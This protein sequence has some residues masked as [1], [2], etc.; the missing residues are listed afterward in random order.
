M[1]RVRTAGLLLGGLVCALAGTGAGCGERGAGAG[2]AARDAGTFTLPPL[3]LDD[4]STGPTAD[5]LETASGRVRRARAELER[6]LALGRPAEGK[7]ACELGLATSADLAG[8]GA[9]AAPRDKLAELCVQRIYPAALRA[10]L[11]RIKAAANSG[12]D[13]VAFHC[14][15]DRALHDAVAA[16]GREADLV[17]A[18]AAA[19][20]PRW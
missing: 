11:A 2:R 15:K 6:V 3:G 17:A 9:A 10:D 4:A 14:D 20:K 13:D 8:Q 7:L 1:S 12:D 19:C 5:D 16:A 18:F